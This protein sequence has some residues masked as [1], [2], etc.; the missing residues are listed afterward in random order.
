MLGVFLL[1]GFCGWENT[2]VYPMIPASLFAPK[3]S[4]F[5]RVPLIEA[6]LSFDVTYNRFGRREFGD[7]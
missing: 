5:T 2:V 3:V 7:R 4:Q 1:L 6:N